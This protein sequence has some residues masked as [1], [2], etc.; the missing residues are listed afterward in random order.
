MIFFI[1]LILLKKM[2]FLLTSKSQI[3]LNQTKDII[4]NLFPNSSLNSINISSNK[5]PEQP[6][7]QDII[8]CAYERI[9]F[10]ISSGYA[11][12]YDYIIAI[13]SGIN[14]ISGEEVCISMLLDMNSGKL[15]RGV[16]YSI[17]TP[18]YFVLKMLE[19]N[20]WNGEIYGASKTMGLCIAEVFPW[21]DHKRWMEFLHKIPEM[22]DK[23]LLKKHLPL[24]PF[25]YSYDGE[26]EKISEKELENKYE[27]MMDELFNFEFYSREDQIADS[28][29]R[30]F[31]KAFVN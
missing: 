24:I 23:E 9:M 20:E 15:F 6:L 2:K 7:D 11:N 21:V 18:H 12:E 22:Y 14:T 31:E 5:I 25:S 4:S 30:L 3:K 26:V 13:E 29:Y 27:E 16:S 28:L 1:K 8:K 17:P 19:D 10:S